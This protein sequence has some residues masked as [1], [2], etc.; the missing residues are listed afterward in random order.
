MEEVGGGTNGYSVAASFDGRSV[1]SCV[2]FEG[3]RDIT[4]HMC[5]KPYERTDQLCQAPEAH[6]ILE[7]P[8]HLPLFPHMYVACGC[9]RRRCYCHCSARLLVNL[10]FV[11][12]ATAS[13]PSFLSRSCATGASLT[14]DRWRRRHGEAEEVRGVVDQGH[15]CWRDLINSLICFSSV[16]DS[17]QVF[18]VD[19]PRIGELAAL[20][21]GL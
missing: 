17:D 16:P 6:P 12:P 2:A 9:C 13:R 14:V 10:V 1:S 19:W 3:V 18:R 7:K 15:G 8:H 20:D 11:C 4:H 5:E 21:N